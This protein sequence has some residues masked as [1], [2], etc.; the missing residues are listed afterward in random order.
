MRLKFVLAFLPF[1]AAAQTASTELYQIVFLRPDPAR[2][3]VTKEEG[4]RIQ[5]AHMANINA[6]AER[7]VLVAAGPFDDK[8]HTIGGVFIFK[9]ASN[10]EAMR[11]ASED[12]TVVEHRNKLD[13]LAWRGPK[14]IGEEYKRLHKE[15][16]K[17]P[18]GMG[19]QPFYL[20]HRTAE[21]KDGAPLLKDH[22]AYVAELRA[23]GKLAAAGPVQGD[24]SVA[25]VLIFDR[26]PDDEAAQLAAADPAVKAGLLRV[27]SHRWWCAANVLPRP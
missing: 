22:A 3:P 4:E 16:P 5:T 2:K 20:L 17:T 9:T 26:I 7:G 21:W 15:D 27:E 25:G 13:V 11:V 10:E 24:S 19:V 1:L 12:P 6:M 14:G 18:V 8:Q 23:K